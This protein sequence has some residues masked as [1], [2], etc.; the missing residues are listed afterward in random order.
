LL[1]NGKGVD[2]TGHAQGVAVT[3]TG[4]GII[5]HGT[6]GTGVEIAGEPNFEAFGKSK[7]SITSP[8][9]DIGDNKITIHGS[10]SIEL[11][12]G[13]NSI[14]LDGGGI[15]INGTKV[16]VAGGSINSSASGIHEI[17]GGMVKIN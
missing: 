3:G 16:T 2:I 9:V 8:D 7:A 10:T 13:G 17:A 4:K 5:V 11:I 1:G 12:V 15:S 14:K 6:G